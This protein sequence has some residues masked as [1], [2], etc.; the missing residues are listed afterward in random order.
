MFGKLL[1]AVVQVVEIPVA[2]V[3]DVVTLGGVATDK[4]QPYTSEKIDEIKQTLDE[5]DE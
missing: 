2:V 3:K 4:R 5:M 1:K